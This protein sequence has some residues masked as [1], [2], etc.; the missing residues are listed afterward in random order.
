MECPL[1]CDVTL[2]SISE[3]TSHLDNCSNRDLLING[4]Y[5]LCKYDSY[6]I[7]KKSDEENHLQTCEYKDYDMEGNDILKWVFRSDINS[8]IES[9]KE[10]TIQF[11]SIQL[12]KS[13]LKQLY[14]T[15][16]EVFKEET[17]EFLSKLFV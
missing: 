7:I 1:K 2:Q 9:F 13:Y 10:K 8:K 5:V 4:E 14:N 3:F 16:N 12:N 11:E 17:K 15:S 6:H